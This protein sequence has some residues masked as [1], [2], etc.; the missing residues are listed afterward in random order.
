M[1][2]YSSY[3]NGCFEDDGTVRTVNFLGDGTNDGTYAL[4]VYTVGQSTKTETVTITNNKATDSAFHGK[5]FAK[6]PSE[7]QRRYYKISKIE[8]DEEGMVQVD[9]LYY[10]TKD[11][12]STIALDVLD[13]D[14]DIFELVG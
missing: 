13:R 1:Q 11:R 8:L 3:C 6:L 10:P 9:A 5:L 14:G 2:P 12:Q 4:E 7:K